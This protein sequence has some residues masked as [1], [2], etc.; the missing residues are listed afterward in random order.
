MP[1]ARTEVDTAALDALGRCLRDCAGEA[2][3][4]YD[5]VARHAADTGDPATQAALAEL[6]AVL[7]QA[8]GR[9]GVSLAESAR[10]VDVAAGRYVDVERDLD[11]TVDLTVRDLR[12]ARR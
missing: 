8:F 10:L 12:E 2:A 6:A 9:L 3:D 1:A 4:V 7:G 5:A 11:V